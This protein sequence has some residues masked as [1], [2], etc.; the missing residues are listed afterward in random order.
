MAN[1]YCLV[2]S[3]WRVDKKELIDKNGRR[4]KK[5]RFTLEARYG[6]KKSYL[7]CV[8]FEENIFD[9]LQD[10]MLIELTDYVPENFITYDQM[11]GERKFVNSI[12]VRSIKVYSNNMKIE[13]KTKSGMKGIEPLSPEDTAVLFESE[14]DVDKAVEQLPETKSKWE[15]LQ[16][17]LEIMKNRAPEDTEHEVIIGD[18]DEIKNNPW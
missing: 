8:S 7:N 2:G 11:T 5:I 1:S 9:L 13:G 18:E 6:R 10:A 15:M 16:E 3:V 14:F 17:Q 12:R 4:T